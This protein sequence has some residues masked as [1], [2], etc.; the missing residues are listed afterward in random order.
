MPRVLKWWWSDLKL[1]SCLT[2]LWSEELCQ[3]FT[4]ALVFNWKWKMALNWCEGLKPIQTGS[5]IWDTR[6]GFLHCRY[7]LQLF[8]NLKV[9]N[10]QNTICS[11]R[12]HKSHF[13]DFPVYITSRQFP[14]PVRWAECIVIWWICI[15]LSTRFPRFFPVFLWSQSR[16][17]VCCVWITTAGQVG[18]W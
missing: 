5:Y 11:A 7:L 9:T 12:T 8:V 3:K 15:R 16:E 1:K 13:I 4:L 6:P 2:S 10:K 17:N 14:F 18:Q